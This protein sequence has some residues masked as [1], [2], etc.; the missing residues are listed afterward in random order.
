[1]CTVLEK[2]RLRFELLCLLK[3]KLTIEMSKCYHFMQSDC[4]RLCSNERVN[5]ASS[6]FL[7][8]ASELEVEI[9]PF[10]ETGFWIYKIYF[11]K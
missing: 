9:L 5:N 1:M 7:S 6:K 8:K 4:S 10:V 3:K 2:D 11:L